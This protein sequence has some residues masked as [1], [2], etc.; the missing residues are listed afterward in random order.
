MNDFCRLYLKGENY[1]MKK[2]RII[3]PALGLIALGTAA[4]ITGTVAWFSMNTQVTITGMQVTT[5]VSSNLQIVGSTLA[6]TAKAEDNT[7][8]TSISGAVSGILEPV[9]TIDGKHFF[10]TTDANGSG[11]ANADAYTK[12]NYTAAEGASEVPQASDLTAFDTAYGNPSSGAVGYLDYVFQLK[13]VNSVALAREIKVTKLDLIYLDHPDTNK[14]FRV[15]IFDE[16][17]NGSAF[18]AAS[19]T[20]KGIYA[21]NGAGNFSD[22]VTGKNYAVGAESGAPTVISTTDNVYNGDFVVCS[23]LASATEYHK[24]VVRLYLEGEDTTCNNETFA[25]LNEAWKLNLEL[26]M[27]TQAGSDPETYT[28]VSYMGK[29]TSKEVTVSEVL[30]RYYYDGAYFWTDET[31]LGTAS[32]DRVAQASAPSE[33]KTAFGIGA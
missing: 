20:L 30:K 9:S 4:S 25:N 21:P 22:G 18:T 19:G 13:A 10:Y 29:Y 14:A 12:Y 2:S 16:K 32:A 26:S 24:V 11:D 7:F 3:I 33:V 6:T 8:V 1:I 15:A 28:A 31:K 23:V 5:R 17:Y 27:D